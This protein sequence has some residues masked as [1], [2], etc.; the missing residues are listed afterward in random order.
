MPFWKSPR[1]DDW[2]ANRGYRL[3]RATT[4]RSARRPGPFETAPVVIAGAADSPDGMTVHGLDQ[5]EHPGACLTGVWVYLGVA[6]PE[7]MVK[8]ESIS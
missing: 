4:Y 7:T 5:N 8:A 2:K 1:L 6:C 3:R